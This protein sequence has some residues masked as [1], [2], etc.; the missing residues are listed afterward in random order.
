MEIDLFGTITYILFK[1]KNK[2]YASKVLHFDVVVL[3]I[4]HQYIEVD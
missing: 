1:I 3:A 4:S 2:E